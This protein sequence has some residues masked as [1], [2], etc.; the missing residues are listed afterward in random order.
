MGETIKFMENWRH[1]FLTHFSAHAISVENIL[2]LFSLVPPPPP[3]LELFIYDTYFGG[4]STITIRVYMHLYK[5]KTV[6]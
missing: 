2:A 3:C 5:K 1:D 4:I 6:S